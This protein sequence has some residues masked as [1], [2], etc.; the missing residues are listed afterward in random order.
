MKHRIALVAALA[1]LALP[2]AALAASG[3]APA[4]ARPAAK[5]DTAINW[6]IPLAPGTAYP[7]AKGSAQYQA[8]QG[9]REFQAEVEHIASLAGTRVTFLVDGVK[10]GSRTVSSRGRAQMTRNTERGQK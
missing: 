2:A 6:Q 4:S 5:A 9:Q 1:L 7:Q 8:Q 10:V 3:A